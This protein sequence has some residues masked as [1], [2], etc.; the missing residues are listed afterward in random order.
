VKSRLHRAR[1]RLRRT[2]R[3]AAAPVKEL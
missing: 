2:L 1:Q 3:P